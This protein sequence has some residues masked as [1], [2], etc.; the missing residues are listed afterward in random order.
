MIIKTFSNGSYLEYARGQFD[1]W[2]VYYVSASGRKP[3]HD[4][5]YFTK[6]REYRDAYGVEKVYD[7][8]VY[9]YDRT[10]KAIDDG[11]LA[12]ITE[13]ASTYNDAIEADVLFTTLYMAMVAEENK[14]NT[15]LGKRIKRLGIYKVLIEDSPIHE[16][17]NIMRGMK[18]TDIDKL[19][20]ERGF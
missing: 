9:V 20:K 3:P 16:A 18:W 15:R 4:I 19:C 17:A 5:D 11:V 6:I 13:L 7:D 2:C 14:R 10:S 1:D 12:S 8:F